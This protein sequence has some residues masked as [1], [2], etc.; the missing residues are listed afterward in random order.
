M[1][2]TIKIISILL[3]LSSVFAGC[4]KY[5]DEKSD[6]KL[7]IPSTIQ[8][9]QILLE[10][11]RLI[12]QTDPNSGE[13]SADNYYLTDADWA[14]LQ[15]TERRMYTWEKDFLFEPSSNAWSDSYHNIY[16]TNTVL[17]YIDKIKRTA[18][19]QDEFDDLLGQAYF[20]RGKYFLQVAWV[21]APA[22]DLVTANSDLGIPLR[23]DPDFNKKSVRSTVQQTYDQVIS[24]LKSAMPLLPDA[25]VHVM[26]PSKAAAYGYLAR[27]YLSMR[28]YDSCF[29]YADLC[30]QLKNDLM[31]Y[32]SAG[33][34]INPDEYYPFIPFTPEVIYESILQYP[35]S[36]YYGSIDSVLFN[37]YDDSDLR[38]TLFF[39]PGGIG[40]E[41][42]KGDY[43][44]G[45]G[46]F[47]GLATDEVYLMRA[48]A[49]ARIGNK[50][51]AMD[52]L[53]TLM[54]KRWKAGLFTDFTAVDAEEAKDKV[55]IERRKELLWRGL[56][57][58]DI[59]RLN[60]EGANIIL[61][62]VING[63][64]YTLPPNDVRYALPI[65]EE[66]I[67]LTGM[68]QNPR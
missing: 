24:D 42:F 43:D 7:V 34:G 61:K 59:K 55:L 2:R 37:S 8:D 10:D 44:G 47:D 57:W 25:P 39:N 13:I 56:R 53:N 1:F 62:R 36:L 12:N 35:S 58:M 48:E 28:K 54:R 45:S 17:E 31:D 26:R 16:R 29:K 33:P 14:S 3:V 51:A 32:N 21:W 22:Y 41:G 30:L 23:L 15:E 46:I 18:N 5:L 65:P 52:D 11:H 60:K 40:P 19:D 20:L 64:T 63:Q 6:Q 4:K 66:V 67:N 27:A 9:L 68:Q 49:N 38:K 50:D